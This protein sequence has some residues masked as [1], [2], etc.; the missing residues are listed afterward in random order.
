[1]EWWKHAFA[2][3]PAAPA[4][5]TDAQRDLIDRLCRELVRRRMTVPAQVV[6]EM[7]RPLNYMSAQLMH[8]FEPFLT[9]LTDPTAYGELSSFLEQ[10]GC[11]EYISN[12]LQ[13]IESDQRADAR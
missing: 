4:E 7:A 1:M 3:A 5:P 13:A 2:V 9:V 10:R 12:R 8:F 11:V 6:L